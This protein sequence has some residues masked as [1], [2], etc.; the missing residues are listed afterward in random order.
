MPSAD[1]PSARDRAATKDPAEWTAD[2]IMM[3]IPHALTDPIALNALLRLLAVRDPHRA[4]QVLDAI[5]VGLLLVE[6][7]R[8]S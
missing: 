6:K 7:G 1:S 8:A 5:E 3:F 4:Q 2:E